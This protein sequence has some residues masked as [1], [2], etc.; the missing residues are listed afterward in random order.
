MFAPTAITEVEPLLGRS[1]QPRSG[2]E[3]YT[4]GGVTLLQDLL[5][6]VVEDYKVPRYQG[7]R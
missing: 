2:D 5:T 1:R 7:S 3:S 6:F 4:I